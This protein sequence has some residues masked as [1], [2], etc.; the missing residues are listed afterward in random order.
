MTNS[1][2]YSPVS[3]KSVTCHSILNNYFVVAE[4][5]YKIYDLFL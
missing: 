3:Q 5:F 2:K 4:D 1:A